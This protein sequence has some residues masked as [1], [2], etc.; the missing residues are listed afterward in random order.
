MYEMISY[1]IMALLAAL[2]VFMGGKWLVAKSKL[3]KVSLL[4]SFIVEAASD[5]TIS[6]EEVQK[7]VELTKTIGED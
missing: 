6:A 7:I 4:L 5:D 2:N 3:G 1:I